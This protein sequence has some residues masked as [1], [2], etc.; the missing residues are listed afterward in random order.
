MK[1][2]ERIYNAPKA[3]DLTGDDY[4]VVRKELIIALYEEISA[5]DK[6]I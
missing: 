5:R 1:F 6:F 4:Y 3:N 2:G